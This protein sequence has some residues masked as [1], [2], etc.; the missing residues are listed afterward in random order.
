MWSVLTLSLCFAGIARVDAAC[1]GVDCTTIPERETVIC[2]TEDL[3]A[4]SPGPI[5]VPWERRQKVTFN[6]TLAE[7]V[8]LF[9]VNPNG[10]EELVRQLSPG[11]AISQRTHFGHVFRFRDH[12]GR[13]LLQHRVGLIGIYNDAQLVR[14][15]PIRKG[16]RPKP[17]GPSQS[18]SD[19]G[20]LE[21]GPPEE[22]RQ[23]HEF[24]RNAFTEAWIN[25]AELPLEMFWYN[26]KGVRGPETLAMLEP[27]QC[28]CECT[29]SRHEFRSFVNDGRY[30]ATR[31]A[32]TPISMPICHEIASS[33][34]D[35]DRLFVLD[36][37][38]ISF[39][40]ALEATRTNC[41]R[42]FP[43]LIMSEKMLKGLF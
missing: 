24:T 23:Q 20:F 30:V 8:S 15:S 35:T 28:T 25:R 42:E 36:G 16:R 41:T 37:D 27:S 29:Y 21:S 18:R 12:M 38:R 39:Q 4:A 32:D 13:T 33:W 1:F 5:N 34:A 10:R 14:G 3:H 6:N 9:W 2:P 17:T 22:G 31:I 7:T 26:D 43:M 19:S 11:E 40:S